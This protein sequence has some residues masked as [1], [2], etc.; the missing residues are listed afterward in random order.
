MHVGDYRYV[1]LSSP[2]AHIEL[3]A[4][5]TLGQSALASFSVVDENELEHVYVSTVLC[6]FL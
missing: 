3:I 4:E 1:L 6:R 2:H 5:L